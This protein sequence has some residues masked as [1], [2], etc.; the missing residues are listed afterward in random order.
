LPNAPCFWSHDR[1]E[2]SLAD[3]AFVEQQDEVPRRPSERLSCRSIRSEK[4]LYLS[5]LRQITFYR[6]LLPR[7]HD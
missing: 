1:D 6:Y 7:L 3:I 4:R 5:K 2:F